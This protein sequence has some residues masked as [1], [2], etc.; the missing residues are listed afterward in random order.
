MS[1]VRLEPMT[2]ADFD[3]WSQHSVEGFAAQQVAAGLA[4]P[5]EAGAYAAHVFAETL[6]QRLTT[7]AHRFWNVLAR[8]GRTVGHLWLRLRPGPDEVEAYVFDVEIV[9]A[10][11][12]RG[13]GRATMLVAEAEARRLGATVARLNVF[14]YNTAAL[15]LYDRLGYTVA[16]ATLT[17]HLTK[18]QTTLLAGQP[19]PLLAGHQSGPGVG[20]RDLTREEYAEARPALDAVAAGELDRLLPHGPATT[21]ER[22]WAAEV[23]GSA[24]GRVWLSLQHRPDGVHGLVRDL[25]VRP[26][27]RRRGHGRSTVLAVARAAQHLRVVTLTVKATTDATRRLFSTSGFELTARTMTKDL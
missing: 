14:G 16:C 4:A 13:L 3:T 18:N 10:A 23:D 12:G 2:T 25:E 9:P 6:P 19:T 22:L 11:R 7:P 20:L 8:D 17:G 1:T 15:A 21:G 26:G 5:A 24:V 27:L